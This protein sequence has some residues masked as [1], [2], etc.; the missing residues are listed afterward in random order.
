MSETR[1][2]TEELMDRLF[3]EQNLRRFFSQEAE[4]LILPTFSEYLQAMCRQR[5]EVPEHIISRANIDKSYGHQ[6]FSGRRNPSRDTV[7]QLAFGFGMDV[8]DA[9]EML[10]I[11]RKSPLYPRVRRDTA[12]IYCLH[13]HISLIDTQIILDDLDLPVLG[14]E[15]KSD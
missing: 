9:Q 7:I 1:L 12:I 2:K 5:I 10:R 6:L 8:G 14:S 15:R 11:A 3:E 13:N 4:N